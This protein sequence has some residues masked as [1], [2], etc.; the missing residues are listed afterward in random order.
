MTIG[1]VLTLEMINTSIEA[2]I[3]ICSKEYNSV[4]KIAKDIAA[5][6]VMISSVFAVIIG[7]MLFSDFYVYMSMWTFFMHHKL[8]FILLA[9]SVLVSLAY[10]KSGPVEIKRKIMHIIKFLKDALNK[11]IHFG[12]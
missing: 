1:S 3:D 6:A 8:L 9:V 11:K 10:I 4:A 2:I 12:R 7:I 5:G